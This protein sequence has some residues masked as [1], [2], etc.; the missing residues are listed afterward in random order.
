MQT[1]FEIP[2]VTMAAATSMFASWPAKANETDPC[3]ELATMAQCST[4]LAF[5]KSVGAKEWGHGNARPM[6]V[7]SKEATSVLLAAPPFTVR[8][9]A[10]TENLKVLQVNFALVLYTETD[11]VVCPPDTED[12]KGTIVPFYVDPPSQ[13]GLHRDQFRAHA[14]TMVG[15]LLIRQF[16][17]SSGLSRRAPAQHRAQLAATLTRQRRSSREGRA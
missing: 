14:M 7:S 9:R 17:L 11:S 6:F 13:P 1:M 16:K 5:D 4:C 3:W 12:S 8:L 15:E 10:T 2:M